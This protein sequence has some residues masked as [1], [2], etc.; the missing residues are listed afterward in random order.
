MLNPNP[1]MPMP[2]V[3]RN[4]SYYRFS[5]IALYLALSATGEWAAAQ[6]RPSFA[7]TWSTTTTLNEDPAWLTEDYFCFFGCTQ[8]EI[9][10]LTAL[11]DDPANDERPLPVLRAEAA[12]V[13]SREFMSLLT[14]KARTVV[15]GRTLVDTLGEI[16]TRYGHFG[17]TVSVMPLRISEAGD[18]LVFDYETHDTRRIVHMEG[19]APP[20][21]EEPSR[22][23]HSVAHYDGDA[24]VIET[25]GVEEAPFYVS[26]ALGLR[27]SDQL[28]TSERYTLSDGGR[29]LDMVYTVTDPAVLQGEWVWVK[30]W[31]LAPEL[32]LQHHEY[33]CSFAP[34]QR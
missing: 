32:E 28:R 12:A 4:R 9:S 23:G 16:C 27:H 1:P 20:R 33:D 21:P 30:K 31:R 15:E 24:L 14:E 13:G 17:M 8:V 34:A 5:L 7:G 6:S 25:T 19:T 2:S 11:L 29:T 3:Y 10:H 22:L 26:M 18:Q